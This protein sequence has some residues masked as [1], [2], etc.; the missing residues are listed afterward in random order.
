[1]KILKCI[2]V[3]Y[4]IIYV[5]DG[6]RYSAYKRFGTGDWQDAT[7]GRKISDSKLVARLE[8]A[9]SEIDK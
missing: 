3:S 6:G 7:D 1:M 2:P 4:T 9:Y 5:E 8:R